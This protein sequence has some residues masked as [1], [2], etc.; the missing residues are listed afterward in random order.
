MV[1]VLTYLSLIHLA[2]YDKIRHDPEMCFYARKYADEMD[3][4]EVS[5]TPEVLASGVDTPAPSASMADAIDDAPSVIDTP[6][7]RT[8]AA[9]T[10]D[11]VPDPMSLVD[12]PKSSIEEK[13][14]EESGGDSVTPMVEDDAFGNNVVVEIEEVDVTM[15]GASSPLSD[16]GASPPRPGASD[17]INGVHTWPGASEL[18]VRV[19]RILAAF[20]RQ[21]ATDTRRRL[22]KEQLD[23]KLQER[24]D[25]NRHL[26][27]RERTEFRRVLLSF[28]IET[29]EGRVVWDRFRE[30]SGIKRADDIMD[31]HYEKTLS[32][33]RECIALNDAKMVDGKGAEKDE[34]GVPIRAES[35]SDSISLDV[36]KR[37]LKRIEKMRTLR[38]EIIVHEKFDERIDNLKRHNRSGLPTWWTDELDK[39]FLR[40]IARWGITRTESMVEGI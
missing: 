5:A 33:I 12:T 8:S 39:S 17:I 15:T 40:G 22:K 25:R 13:T 3:V 10:N 37:V 16:V 20:L 38:Q 4:P 23:E 30:L 31:E 1:M 19:R 7:Q 36:A 14:P 28:G 35:G 27:K 29:K 32:M 21:M 11:D 2:Q 6:A 9:D 34:A 26:T 24:K 18:G